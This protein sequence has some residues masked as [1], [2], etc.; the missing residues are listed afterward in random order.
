[1]GHNVAG[2]QP[3]VGP[4]EV[5]RAHTH[6]SSPRSHLP[7]SPSPH[8]P[9]ISAAAVYA[10]WAIVSYRPP[11]HPIAVSVLAVIAF[12]GLGGGGRRTHLCR[13]DPEPRTLSWF[14]Q[15]HLE[16]LAS[17]DC[18]PTDTRA[19]VPN[20]TGCIDVVNG[21]WRHARVGTLAAIACCQRGWGGSAAWGQRVAAFSKRPFLSF[22]S[23]PMELRFWTD[24]TRG[25]WV[26][27]VL[28]G[29]VTGLGQMRWLEVEV[30]A[31]GTI[32]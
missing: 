20:R 17:A 6:T 3:G 32:A 8:A 21:R 30:E 14:V 24:V 11:P 13:P 7:S 2:H 12:W 4:N 27:S 31:W 28:F 23:D 22:P 25:A 9:D 26:T 29:K 10:S 1:M 19:S 16:R 15:D 5:K 18:T